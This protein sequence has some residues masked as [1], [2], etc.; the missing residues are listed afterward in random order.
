MN[1]QFVQSAHDDMEAILIYYREQGVPDQGHPIPLRV[2]SVAETPDWVHPK[3]A[4]RLVGSQQGRRLVSEIIKKSERLSKHPDSGRMV[5]EFGMAF[6]RE[7]IYP[8]F[9]VV[10]RRD[11]H[12]ISVIRV[13]RSERI[14]GFTELQEPQAIYNPKKKS[15]S[16][17][18]K[19]IK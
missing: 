6:L 19:G 17:K 1:V 10:Y 11:P 5:P 16:P 2:S 13:W 9:R 4:T 18:K 7:V 8:P 3:L 12:Q 14:I 15:I